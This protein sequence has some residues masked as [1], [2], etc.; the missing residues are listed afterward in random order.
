MDGFNSPYG[1]LTDYK[2]KRIIIVLQFLLQPTVSQ[3]LKSM[4]IPVLALFGSLRLVLLFELR[5]D[6]LLIRKLP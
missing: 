1:W 4:P 6:E 5:V 2:R 3:I